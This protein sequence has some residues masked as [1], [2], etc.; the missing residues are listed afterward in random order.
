MLRALAFLCALLLSGAA[1]AQPASGPRSM[2]PTCFGPL[3]AYATGCGFGPGPMSTGGY[4]GP[5]DIVPS[6]TAFYSLRCGSSAL[7]TGTTK[8]VNVRRASDNATQDIV[9]LSNGNFDSATASAFAG[10]DATASCSTTGLSTTAACTGASATPHVGDPVSCSG[11]SQPLYLTGV[12][13]F[14]AGAGTVTLSTAENIAVATT[15]TF[16]VALFLPKWY[17]QSGNPNDQLQATAGSQPQ[18][19]L[20][21]AKSGTLPCVFFNGSTSTA[22]TIASVTAVS[23][24]AVGIRTAAFT[25]V[26]PYISMYVGGNQLTLENSGS[27]NTIV[28]YGGSNLSKASADSVW[29]SLQGVLAAGTAGVISVDGA[30]TT[31][32]TG[33]GA[34]GTVLRLGTQSAS[35]VLTGYMSESGIW[36]PANN[37]TKRAALCHNQTYWGAFGC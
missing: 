18:L 28:I 20:S 8:V 31:G 1:V 10:T 11:C 15:F 12:G 7:A 30:E 23:A 3:S 26:S 21:C 33:V 2:S 14:V 13:S 16:Q 19:L 5:L 27:T 29:H 6:A 37:S 25:T 32:T 4:I 35:P 9:C 34:A 24:N 17:D 36:A 22:A